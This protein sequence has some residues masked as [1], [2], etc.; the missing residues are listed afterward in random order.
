MARPLLVMTGPL[1]DLI[2]RQ[3]DVVFEVERLWEAAE[4]AARLAAISPNVQAIAVGYGGDAIT[5]AMMD[6]LPRL[7]VIANFGVG[8]DSVDAKAAA[9]RGIIVTNTP[10]VLTEETADTAFG[11][12][13]MTV[14]ELSKAETYLRAGHWTNANYPLTP[15][16]L[17]NR[18][19]G[20]VGLGRIGKAIARRCEASLLPVAYWGRSRKSDVPYTYF[21]DLVEMARAVDTM[22]A[23]IPGGPA[24]E[25]LINRPV[26]EALGPRGIFINMARGS[27]VDEPALIDALQSKTIAAAG[28][29]VMLGEPDIDKRLLSLDNAVLL[30]HVGSASHHTRDAMGQ[31][32]VDNLTAFAAG[33]PPIS[34]V[35][36]TPFQGWRR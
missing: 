19:I 10:D 9:Q 11:L 2:Q 12:L 21:S 27:I 14:R 29:D 18:K 13:I 8:Y 32:V 34:P 7:Q 35:V 5:A 25:R 33:K 16:T 26:F 4:P 6:A 23:V 20:I 17:R 15:H 30:P 1:M 28:L 3:L 24:T 22:I 36:E 31:L